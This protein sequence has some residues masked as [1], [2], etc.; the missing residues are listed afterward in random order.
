MTDDQGDKLIRIVFFLLFLL[1]AINYIREILF[2]CSVGTIFL[3]DSSNFS[4]SIMADVA[5]NTSSELNVILS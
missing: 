3:V 5:K 4:N 1:I 2:F